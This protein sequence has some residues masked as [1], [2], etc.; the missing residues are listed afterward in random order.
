MTFINI[1]FWHWWQTCFTDIKSVY[2][3]P[4][5]GLWCWDLFSTLFE[6]LRVS[7]K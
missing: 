4:F 5:A 7:G 6:A 1:H 3:S 2:I